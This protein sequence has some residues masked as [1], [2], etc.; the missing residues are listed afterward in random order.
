M[1]LGVQRKAVSHKNYQRYLELSEH[2]LYEAIQPGSHKQVFLNAKRCFFSGGHYFHS[3]FKDFSKTTKDCV[4]FAL[5]PKYLS[6][7]S[8][9]FGL[10]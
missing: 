7:A 1:I 9:S 4:A 8:I 10:R 5:L 6:G 2:L 3:L